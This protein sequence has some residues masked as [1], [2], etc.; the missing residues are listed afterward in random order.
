[1]SILEDS[2]QAY[3]FVILTNHIMIIVGCFLFEN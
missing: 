2:C 3:Y 1:M